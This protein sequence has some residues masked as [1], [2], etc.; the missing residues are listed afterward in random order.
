MCT[1]AFCYWRWIEYT[2]SA[3]LMVSVAF[4]HHTSTS[5]LTLRTLPYAQFFCLQLTIGIRDQSTLTLSWTLMALV[6]V[7]GLATEAWSR[8]AE[9]DADGY[10]GWVGDPVRTPE[11]KTLVMKKRAWGRR[12]YIRRPEGPV[13]Y[14]Y[15]QTL[16]GLSARERWEYENQSDPPAPNPLTYRERKILRDYAR[17]YTANYLFRMLPHFIGWVPYLVVWFQYFLH[18]ITQLNDLR[19]KDEDLFDRVPDFVPWAIGATALWFTSFTFVQWRY[20]FVSPDFYWKSEWI[21]SFLSAGAKITLGLL[22]YIN[23]SS[24]P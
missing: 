12:N 23:V 24:Q 6:M 11:I 13:Q 4:E 17:A 22:L 19:L 18:F 1:Q 5:R 15:E 3:P 10:R 7:C 8:P 21:Y 20:Q 14:D 2:A 16:A 9:R